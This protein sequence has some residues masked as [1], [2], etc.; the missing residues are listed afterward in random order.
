[1]CWKN[2]TNQSVE[3]LAYPTKLL[4]LA[5]RNWQSLEDSKKKTS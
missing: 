4:R 3:R 2:G 5:K 1:M